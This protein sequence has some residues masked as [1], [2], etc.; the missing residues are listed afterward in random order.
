MAHQDL[1]PQAQ[2]GATSAPVATS[3]SSGG[4]SSHHMSSAV[5]LLPPPPTGLPPPPGAVPPPAGAAPVLPPISLDLKSPPISITTGSAAT[6]SPHHGATNPAVTPSARKQT[7]KGGLTLVFDGGASEG[8]EI[9]MEELRL[10]EPRYQAIL[11]RASVA[12]A[13]TSLPCLQK[14]QD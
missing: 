12:N 13:V 4:G 9:S 14:L 5:G 3:L 8:E 1:I 2:V 6:L 10:R 7:L 11:A